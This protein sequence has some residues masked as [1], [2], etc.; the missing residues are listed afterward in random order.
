MR[1]DGIVL[2]F[3]P[4]QLQPQHPRVARAYYRAFAGAK[5]LSTAATGEACPCGCGFAVI[6]CFTLFFRRSF[7]CSAV[8]FHMDFR[9]LFAFFW[10][11]PLLSSFLLAK[12][13]N[14]TLIRA[15]HRRKFSVQAAARRETLAAS[16]A[17]FLRT[18]TPPFPLPIVIGLRYLHMR[19]QPAH[20]VL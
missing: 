19:F 7:C 6:V 16:S 1:S 4:E 3:R 8:F 11:L 20:K 12:R 13:N 18:S 14:S 5:E 15:S 17:C 2:Q 9:L 10:Q